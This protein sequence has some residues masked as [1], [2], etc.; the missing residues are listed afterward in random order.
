MENSFEKLKY[1][2]AQLA[3]ICASGNV[4]VITEAWAGVTC[5]GGGVNA[6]KLWVLKNS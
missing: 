3:T 5:E 1:V 4:R 6:G 2:G